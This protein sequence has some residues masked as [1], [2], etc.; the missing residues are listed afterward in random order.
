MKNEDRKPIEY[1]QLCAIVKTILQHDPSIDDAEW[2]ARTRDTLAKYGFQEPTTDAL[3]RAMSH[4]EYVLRATVGP[5]PMPTLSAGGY[6]P[7]SALAEHRTHHPAGWD[8]VVSLMKK[9]P[10]SHA[11]SDWVQIGAVAKSP[12]E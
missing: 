8:I 3:A 1:R 12:K 11:A 10:R 9:Q 7:P 2:K 4:M 6:Q 5:R